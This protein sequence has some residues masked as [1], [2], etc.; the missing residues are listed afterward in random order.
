MQV[1]AQDIAGNATEKPQSVATTVAV[2]ATEGGGKK[3]KRSRKKRDRKRKESNQQEGIGQPQQQP[4][5]QQ[6]QQVLASLSSEASG[7]KKRE[8]F[9]NTKF[10]DLKISPLSKR[11]L[12][13]VLKYEWLT[14]VQEAAIPAVASGKDVLARAKTG[15]GKTLGKSLWI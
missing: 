3:K 6:Q 4:Q 5:Q 10:K 1:Q 8:F 13:E 7:A 11:A 12:A 2:A 9:T 14:K 15:T